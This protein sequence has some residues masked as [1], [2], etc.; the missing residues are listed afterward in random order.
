MKRILIIAVLAV[1]L[2]STAGATA[3]MA[4]PTGKAAV[5]QFDVEIA[6]GGTGKLTINPA[7]QT[8]VFNGHGAAPTQ[9]YYLSISVVDDTLGRVLID[10]DATAAAAD[11]S[12]HMKGQCTATMAQLDDTETPPRVFVSP[13]VGG[14]VYTPITGMD[15]QNKGGFV[16]KLA[17]YYSTD[18]GVTWTESDHTGGI[19]SPFW[20]SEYLKTLHVPNDALV[21]IHVIVVAGKDR[22]G[23]E[24]FQYKDVDWVYHWAQYEISGTTLNPTLKYTGLR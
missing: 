9:M 18:G 14:D 17:C 5:R 12:I 22:T 6:G 7:Q 8:F 3:A 21:K 13:R 16:A 15:L 1:L 4:A 23:V 10:L 19:T 11:G 24:L 20:L 2:M